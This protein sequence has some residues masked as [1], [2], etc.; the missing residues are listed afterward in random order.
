[1][2]MNKSNRM[3]FLSAMSLLA[4][5]AAMAFPPFYVDEGA[6]NPGNLPLTQAREGA[7]NVISVLEKNTKAHA[8]DENVWFRNSSVFSEYTYTDSRDERS[9]GFDSHAREGTVG[10]SF[11]SICDVAMSVMAKGGGTESDT[12]ALGHIRNSSA[13]GGLTLTAAKNWDWF[14]AGASASYDGGYSRTRTATGDLYKIIPDGYSFSPFVGAMYVNGDFS[15]STVPTYILNWTKQDY[16]STAAGPLP[17]PDD[18]NSQ[19]TFVWQN[20][21]SYNVCEKVTVGLMAN[22]NCVT[23]YKQNLT[24]PSDMGDRDWLSLGPKVSYN[25]SPALSVYGSFLKD[26]KNATFNTIQGTVGLN[27]NF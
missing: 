3:V 19:D 15:F 27:Y 4:V 23:R 22:W 14:L 10:L 7:Q 26:L 6:G 12:A 21:A 24:I 13:N 16:D 2:T 18:H 5:G 17:N 25:L 9:D 20:T 11:L 8:A 1:M